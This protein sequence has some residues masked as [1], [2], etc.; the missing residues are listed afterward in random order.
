MEEALE[1]IATWASHGTLTQ[2]QTEIEG[3]LK[4]EG[5][6]SEVQGDELL[7][8]KPRKVGGFLGIG[9]KTVKEPVMRISKAEGK[10]QILPEPLDEEFAQYLASCLKQ[11]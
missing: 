11:H 10:V 9:A 7:I 3:Y 8:Y 6:D 5:Y 1:K 2:F 4:K